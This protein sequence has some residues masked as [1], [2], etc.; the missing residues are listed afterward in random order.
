MLLGDM[1]CLKHKIYD[2]LGRCAIW[3]G[4]IANCVH[5]NHIIRCRPGKAAISRFA[6]LY[7][8]SDAGVQVMKELAVTT[9]GLYNLSVGKIRKIPLPIP[10]IA[11]QHRIVAKVNE[12][13][14]LCDELEAQLTNTTTTRR[15]LLETTLHEA[16]SIPV[17][18][19]Q[20]VLY[21]S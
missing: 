14:A 7:L 4:Q 12:L 16:L 10:P 9:S 18:H 5:Q 6:E 13:M 19:G 15:Q 2:R 20:P 21:A 8:N 1:L 3:T 17:I 11:E